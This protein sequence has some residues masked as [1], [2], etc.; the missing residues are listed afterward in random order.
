LRCF[1]INEGLQVSSWFHEGSQ[2]ISTYADRRFKQDAS[3]VVV[4]DSWDL[5]A[6]DLFVGGIHQDPNGEFVKG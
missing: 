5:E 6:G 1:Y 2:L 3:S 4:G